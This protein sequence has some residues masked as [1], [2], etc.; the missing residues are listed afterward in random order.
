[1]KSLVRL[2]L[3]TGCALGALT[4][5]VPALAASGAEVLQNTCITCHTKAPDGTVERI[6]AARKTPEAWDMTVVRMMRNHKVELSD[7][8]RQAV[9]KYLAD[10]RGLSVAETEGFRYILEREPVASDE[11]PSELM[12]QTCGRCHSYARVALQRRTPEDWKHLVNFHLGQFPTLEY[13]ALARDRDWWG[14]AQAEIIPFLAKTYP[15]GSAPAPFTGDPAGTYVLAGHQPAKGDYAGTLTIT[16]AGSEFDVKMVL[17]FADHTATFTGKGRL[18]G[19]GEWRASLSDGKVKIRQVFAFGADGTLEGRWFEAE[20]DVIGGRIAAVK[21]DGAAHALAAFPSR[22]KIGAETTVTVAGSGLSGALTLPAGVTGEI[23]GKNET[24][25]TL[26]LKATAA[27]PVE[28]ALGSQKIALVAYEAPDRISI[29][30]ELTIARIGDNGSPIPKVPAQ[31]EAEGWLNGPDGKPGTAD[32]ISLG[33]FP[34]TWA[35][36]DF[37]EAAAAM[38]DATFAGSIDATGL[39]TPAAAGPNPERVMS[40]NNAGNLKVIATVTEGGKQLT[41][42]AHLYA[43]VQRFVDP[44]IR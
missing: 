11:G 32:D 6:D 8:D 36:A 31:F 39:F 19:A 25:V 28:L 40:T 35:T 44:P 37:D 26:K 29:V 33:Y 7:A 43:T 9:V 2:A 3:A 34:A 18:F 20:R 4:A 24:G 22:L 42:E 27:G 17:A 14:I 23:T 1:M 16:K 41:A 21:A 38:K 12:T 10:T 15:L 30:P 13:Q 5:A